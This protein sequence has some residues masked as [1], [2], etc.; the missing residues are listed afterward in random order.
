MDAVFDL[1]A[2]V[3]AEELSLGAM[4]DVMRLAVAEGEGTLLIVLS[5]AAR[6]AS[7]LYDERQATKGRGAKDA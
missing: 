1:A 5:M 6:A 3:E 4:L 2:A 7:M